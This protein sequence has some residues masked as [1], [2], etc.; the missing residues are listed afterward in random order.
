MNENPQYDMTVPMQSWFDLEHFMDGLAIFNLPSKEEQT[1]WPPAWT[2]APNLESMVEALKEAEKPHLANVEAAIAL[3]CI[4]GEVSLAGFDR[5]TIR[6]LNTR[7]STVA[8][9]ASQFVVKNVSAIPLPAL[10]MG[11]VVRWF[12]CDWWYEHGYLSWC[13]TWISEK[14]QNE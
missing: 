5:E 14:W 13:D 1:D 8:W 7:A 11:E 12:L 9:L 6:L 10:P 3:I 4:S 2:S